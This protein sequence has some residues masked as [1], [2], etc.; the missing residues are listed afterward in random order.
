MAEIDPLIKLK[1]IFYSNPR[2]ALALYKSAHAQGLKVTHKQVKDFVAAQ[3]VAQIHKQPVVNKVYFP[4]RARAP[5]SL[6]NADLTDVS[7][8]AHHNSGINYFLTV[9]DIYS[10]YVFIVP[11]KN[12]SALSVVKA[13]RHILTVEVPSAGHKPPQK[14][15][16]DQGSEFKSKEW[17]KLMDEFKI[18]MGYAK[19]DNHRTLSVLDSFTKSLRRYIQN[20]LTASKQSRYIDQLPEIVKNYNNSWHSSLN[21]TPA[22]PNKDFIEKRIAMREQKANEQLKNYNIGDQV[23][24]IINKALFDKG[25]K[26]KWSETIHTI[27]EISD[28]HRVY[29][30]ENGHEYPYYQLF[31][32]KGKSEQHEYPAPSAEMKEKEKLIPKKQR[33][34]LNK[35]GLNSKDIVPEKEKRVRLPTQFYNPL[36]RNWES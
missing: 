29:K 21:S 9:I 4:I 3:S 22:N 35:E 14:I 5:D 6:Y 1:E 32:I 8:E 31:L 33:L 13:M 11:L 23:R 30:L 16:S 27:K 28:N 17:L 7:N 15:I 36:T 12:K 18:D 19:L 10:R 20:Y 34:Q 24:T 25:H 26:P 2:G